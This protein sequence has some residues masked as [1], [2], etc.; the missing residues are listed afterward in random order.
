MH[1]RKIGLTILL[2][3]VFMACVAQAGSN[4]RCTIGKVSLAQGDSGPTYDLY[5]RSYVGKVFTIDRISGLMTGALKNSYNTKPQVIDNGSDNNSYKV[6]TTMRQEE[7]VGAG[8][9]IYALT[10]LEYEK[11]LNKPFI[12]L[13]N[14]AVFFGQCEH[15]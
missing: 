2:S 15:F 4:Y 5:K 8:S 1:F 14:E 3:T 12:Y 10:V 13:D 11:T 6:V 9:N 7:G